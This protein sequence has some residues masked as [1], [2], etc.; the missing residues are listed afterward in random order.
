MTNTKAEIVIAPSTGW[1]KLDFKGLLKYKDLIILMVGRD[2]AAKYRQTILG[3][4][5]FIIQ[6]LLTTLV[7]TVIFGNVAGIPT[8]GTPKFLF[9]L[10]GLLGWGY[11]A[12]VLTHTGNTFV[13]H[14]GLMTKVYFPRMVLPLTALLSQLIALSIQIATFLGFY[15]Y[16]LLFT[17]WGETVRLNWMALL[18]P[19]LIL[20]AG[21]TA[22]GVGCL[23]SAASAKYRDLN[24]L[25]SFLVQIWMYATPIIYP[26]SKIPER[27]QI[28]MALNP[29][30]TIVE[31]IKYGFLG[32]GGVP[33]INWLI[34][35]AVTIS[36]FLIGAAVF[37]RTERLFV[38]T[39]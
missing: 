13:A 7:F 21:I 6:P 5:W 36:V 11:F 9:Y 20:Q 31:S 10:S 15:V 37:R 18:F 23:T 39:V 30:S 29:L 26:F 27:F 25:L 24:F 12:G 19:V 32:V 17:E 16:F 35:G 33:P 3:P 2:F 38:D 22:L 4:A 28:W 34:S 14:K 8:D 1:A